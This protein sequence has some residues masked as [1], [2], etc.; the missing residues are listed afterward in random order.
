MAYVKEDFNNDYGKWLKE[1]KLLSLDDQE[2]QGDILI[3]EVMKIKKKELKDVKMILLTQ[4][5]IK[6]CEDRRKDP[7][8]NFFQRMKL[9][10]NINTMRRMEKRIRSTT[11]KTLKYIKEKG[12]EN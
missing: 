1:F 7:K 2:K 5:L 11:E 10:N 12:S 4:P 6:V 9:R 8:T 3:L